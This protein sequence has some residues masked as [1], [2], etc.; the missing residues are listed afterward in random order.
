MCLALSIDSSD[1]CVYILLNLFLITRVTGVSFCCGSYFDCFD[2]SDVPKIR[3]GTGRSRSDIF[4]VDC[5]DIRVDI[6]T[7][8]RYQGGN[9]G[10][11]DSPSHPQ[12]IYLISSHLISSSLAQPSPTQYTN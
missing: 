4:G 1:N 10:R 5:K 11:S 2:A 3:L 12:L 9:D 7:T 8:G 6:G